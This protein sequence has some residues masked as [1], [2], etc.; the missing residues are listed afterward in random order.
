MDLLTAVMKADLAE[1]RRLLEAGAAIDA[2]DSDSRTALMHAVIDGPA[3][4]VSLLLEMGADP[5]LQDG[6]GFSPLHFAAQEQRPEVARLLLG[7]G[8]EVDIADRNG[9]T[10]LARA[11]FSSRGR[12]QVIRILLCEGADRLRENNFGISP[13]K[14]ARSIANYDLEDLLS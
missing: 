4:L 10:P 8:A 3:E 13:L 7:G 2:A 5:N 1:V 6:Q 14:L 12:G 11:I 9:N